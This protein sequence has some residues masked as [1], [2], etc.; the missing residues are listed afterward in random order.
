ME[1]QT[2][3]RGRLIDH[4][5]LVVKDLAAS[6]RFYTAALDIPIGGTGE[7]YFWADEL[8]VTAIDSPAALGAL[9]GRHHLAFQAQDRAMVDRFYQAALA[10]GGQDNGAPG[11]R[12]YHPGYYAAF[13]LDPDGNNIE[14]VYHGEAKRNAESVVI[15]Y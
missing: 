9:T 10:H 7:G 1:T 15:T 3:H 8:F 4:L 14:A 5:Q 6:Q 13:V 11:E 2:L 12:N